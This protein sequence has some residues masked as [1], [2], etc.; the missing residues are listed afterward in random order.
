MRSC[1]LYLSRKELQLR[2]KMHSFPTSIPNLSCKPSAS[3]R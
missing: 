2:K 1:D 3:S